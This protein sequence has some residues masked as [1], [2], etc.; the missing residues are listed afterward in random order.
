MLHLFIFLL[1][2]CM[3]AHSVIIENIS[4]K[5]IEEVT[6]RLPDGLTKLMKCGPGSKLE[7]EPAR[8]GLSEAIVTVRRH[9]MKGTFNREYTLRIS[10]TLKLL[11]Q[12]KAEVEGK[13]AK[14]RI[15]PDRIYNTP[16]LTARSNSD[17]NMQ[18][19][20]LNDSPP[21]SDEETSGEDASQISG[22]TG[23]DKVGW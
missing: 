3:P 18:V 20:N 19:F 21:P 17:R 11:A 12:A 8:P 23:L 14:F 4:D 10:D 13:K 2:T 6:V 9:G 15:V 5:Y 1:A 16:H 7:I 22:C